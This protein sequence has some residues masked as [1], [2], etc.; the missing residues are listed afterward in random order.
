MQLK[1][2]AKL[3]LYLEVTGKRTDG[4]H[5]LESQVVFLNLA[6]EISVVEDKELKI[7]DASG[8]MNFADNII[9]KTALKL[10]TL[11]KGKVGA[12][13]TYKKNIPV[14]GGLGG[15]SADAAVV[16]VL[17]NDLWNLSLTPEKLYKIALEIGSDVPVCLFSILENTNSAIFK[18]IGEIVKKGPVLKKNFFVLINP[19]KELLTKTV[20][21]NFTYKSKDK[22][23]ERKND[24]QETAIKLL[25]EI[26]EIITELKAIKTCKL[27]RMTGSGATCFGQF[28]SNEAAVDAANKISAEHPN[29]FIKVVG[30][31]E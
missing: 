24:L 9:M 6:D 1:A 19:N 29:W 20:F 22:L 25:P 18:G 27:A 30:L 26:G 17:L 3:N 14:G 2:H 8:K 12:K 10:S 11:T 28:W 7:I 5:E 15:G 16:L 13:I 21:E 4:Y 23:T 31:K